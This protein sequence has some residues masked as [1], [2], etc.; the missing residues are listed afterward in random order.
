V[1]S[2]FDPFENINNIF[3]FLSPDDDLP[4]ILMVETNISDLKLIYIQAPIPS[5]AETHIEYGESSIL[6]ENAYLQSYYPLAN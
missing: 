2:Y 1:N 4:L 3:L 6:P 5:P